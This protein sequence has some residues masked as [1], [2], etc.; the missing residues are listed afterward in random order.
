MKTRTNTEWEVL[1]RTRWRGPFAHLPKAIRAKLVRGCQG[2]A[3]YESVEEALPII[4]ALPVRNG[5]FI[6]AYKCPL[7]YEMAWVNGEIT[8]IPCYHIGNSRNS[9][10]MPERAINPNKST[11]EPT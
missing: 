6:R 2:K 4:A 8:Y 5:M 11:N 7:C 10:H 3:V 9:Q 1:Y